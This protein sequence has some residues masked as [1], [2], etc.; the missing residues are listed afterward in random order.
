[1]NLFG[2]VNDKIDP[3]LDTYDWEHI[4][5]EYARPDRCVPDDTTTPTDPFTREDVETIFGLL[6]GDNDGPSWVGVFK[7]KDGRYAY[8][9]GSCD[10][11][12]WG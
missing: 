11:T 9:T 7:L 3:R 8:L 2:F 5:N 4:F 10:Y 1:M 6:E 12:G